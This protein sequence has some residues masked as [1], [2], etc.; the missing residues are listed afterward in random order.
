MPVWMSVNERGW[1]PM[2]CALRYWGLQDR[3]D[4]QGTGWEYN[5]APA[6]HT[7]RVAAEWICVWGTKPL[8]CAVIVGMPEVWRI[9]Y[10]EVNP[11]CISGCEGERKCLWEPVWRVLARARGCPVCGPWLEPWTEPNIDSTGES[12]SPI[13]YCEA[14]GVKNDGWLTCQTYSRSASVHVNI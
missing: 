9:R 8:S 10:S 13:L 12:R 2:G 7:D 4:R 3:Q 14:V 1:M 5:K 6:E 11:F